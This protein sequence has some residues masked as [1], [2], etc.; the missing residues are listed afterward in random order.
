[1]CCAVLCSQLLYRSRFV[2]QRSTYVQL[3][4]SVE[5]QIHRMNA[6]QPASQPASK[7]A[8]QRQRPSTKH[9]YEYDANAGSENVAVSVYFVCVSLCVCGPLCMCECACVSAC[10]P[11]SVCV[12]VCVSF[13]RSL[14][15][16]RWFVR[17][18]TM[19][20]KQRQRLHTV[21]LTHTES[22]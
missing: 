1:M 10:L 6:R 22:Y 2:Q 3:L 19:C 13:I 15:T 17:S 18:S 20:A 16:F 8:S 12:C 11:A 5:Y 21:Q 14:G 4:P 7:Q 9:Q